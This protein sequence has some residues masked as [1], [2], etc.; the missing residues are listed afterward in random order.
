MVRL[1]PSIPAPHRRRALVLGW[2]HLLPALMKEFASQPGE[3]FEIDIFSEVSASKRRKRLNAEEM[4]A[5]SGCIV[6]RAA[7]RA[8]QREVC[9]SVVGNTWR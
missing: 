4:P 3:T 7:L 6:R 5:G 9:S 2:S 8:L 1:P